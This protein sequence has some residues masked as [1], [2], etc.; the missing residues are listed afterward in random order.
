MLTSQ[1][2]VSVCTVLYRSEDVISDFL[3]SLV[4]RLEADDELLLFDNS[5]TDDLQE[6]VAELT[7]ESE[8]RVR[9][10]F[11]GGNVGFA[12][13]CNTLAEQA[14]NSRLV[15][16]NPDIRVIDFDCHSHQPYELVGA[17]ILDSDGQ[18]EYTYGLKRRLADEVS[19]RWLRRRGRR[20]DGAGYVSG[21]ALS[22]DRT[23]FLAEGGFDERFFMYYED[24]DLCLRLSQAGTSVRVSDSWVVVHKGGSSARKV[25]KLSEIRSFD[26]SLLFHQKWDSHVRTFA[27]WSLIDSLLR[28]PV[29]LILGQRTNLAAQ[30][31]LTKHIASSLRSPLFVRAS[32]R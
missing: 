15:F 27:T 18:D 26:S 24:I 3:T 12:R 19:L 1:L 28:L 32:A 7:R 4:P 5:E 21:A 11:N 30:W 6:A 13:A 16:L 23:R 25:R 29:W 22:V 14:S 17:R 20:P 8:C 2:S 31:S 10:F 9:Y